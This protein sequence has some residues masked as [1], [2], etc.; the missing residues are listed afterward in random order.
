[1]DEKQERR[2]NI[3]EAA[4]L[5]FSEKGYH[6]ARVEE[7]AVQAGIGKGTVYE[8][9][10]SKLELFQEMFGTLLGR[11][12]EE[13]YGTEVWE[14]PVVE[15]LRRILVVHLEFINRNARLARVTFVDSYGVDQELDQWMYE[16]R[17]EKVERMEQFFCE[18]IQRGEFR[19]DL[20]AAL[21]A[22][23]FTG[24][25]A[26]VV[27]PVVMEEIEIDA[28]A[29]ANRVLEVLMHGIAAR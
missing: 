20:D 12:F 25:L 29:T 11:W 9:F 1:M 26:S 15:Q 8:Y 28:A 3:L 18:G 6:Q 4:A 17:Q 16:Q 23:I 24:A 5:V 21:L 2:D 14:G 27:V 10:A 7:I 22:Q 19:D 13:L